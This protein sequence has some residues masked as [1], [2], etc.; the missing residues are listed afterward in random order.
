MRHASDHS[1][2]LAVLAFTVFATLAAAAAPVVA[3]PPTGRLFAVVKVSDNVVAGSPARASVVTPDGVLA[4]Y[5]EALLERSPNVRS[6]LLEGL[7]A[8]TYD[9]RVEGEGI[10]TEV[11]RGV[12]V[13]AGRDETAAFVVKPGQGVHIVEYAVAGLSREEVAARLAHLE[14]ETTK[15]RA[16]L[17]AVR[18]KP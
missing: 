18:A 5:H 14:A 3:Q 15:L 11:K 1:V 9:V 2:S 7:P 16:E 10:V 4:D 8:G 6:F 13:F 17:E 12:P